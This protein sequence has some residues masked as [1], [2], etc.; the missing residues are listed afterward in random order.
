MN[1]GQS[2]NEP[3]R[4]GSRIVRLKSKVCLVKEAPDFNCSFTDVLTGL[5]AIW[6]HEDGQ[7]KQQHLENKKGEDDKVKVFS[8][9]IT[10]QVLARRWLAKTRARRE[11]EARA[12]D[13][14]KE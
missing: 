13:N 3:K 7:I 2:S 4:K 14:R 5:V 9:A 8:A 10:F 12:K 6:L 1:K 11:L